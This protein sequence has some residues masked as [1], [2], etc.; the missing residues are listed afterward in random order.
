M[1]ANESCPKCASVEL[2]VV[3]GASTVHPETPDSTIAPMT[4]F[5]RVANP[6][7][8]FFD[9]DTK[10][11][12]SAGFDAW[13]CAGCGYTEWYAKSVTELRSLAEKSSAVRLVSR[14]GGDGPYRK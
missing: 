4:L 1:K 2:L 6:N 10:I 5:F 3:D 14:S 11:V 12:R 7:A 9:S 13:I 8:G